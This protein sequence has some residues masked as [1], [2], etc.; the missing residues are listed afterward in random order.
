M[1]DNSERAALEA[2]SR[3][4][5]SCNANRSD[6]EL[7]KKHFL[8]EWCD[9]R[10]DRQPTATL[11]D[12]A[13]ALWD[14]SINCDFDA[15]KAE[16]A[17]ALPSAGLAATSTPVADSGAKA[18]PA[19][20]MYTMHMEFDQKQVRIEHSLINPFG[21][22]GE[23]YDESYQVTCEPLYRERH[24]AVEGWTRELTGHLFDS[25][26]ESAGLTRHERNNQRI[27]NA[28]YR[29][30][31]RGKL[32]GFDD[33]TEIECGVSGPFNDDEHRSRS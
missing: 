11:S 31:V 5:G 24:T 12:I 30:L 16:V 22:P 15:F 32:Y 2:W 26:M 3:Q 19:A 4:V 8:A 21:V 33:A 7:E 13:G 29:L 23:D 27:R 17:K 9:A 10:A 20:W 6:M 18:T 25:E 14:A 28:V 1:S